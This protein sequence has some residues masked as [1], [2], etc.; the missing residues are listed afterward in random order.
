MG[1]GVCTHL[2][3]KISHKGGGGSLNCWQPLTKGG[4]GSRHD[5]VNKTWSVNLIRH[6][7]T[8][9][10]PVTTTNYPDIAK[11]YPKIPLYCWILPNICPHGLKFGPLWCHNNSQGDGHRGVIWVRSHNCTVTEPIKQHRSRP[12]LNMA[13]TIRKSLWFINWYAK[14]PF[15]LPK[16]LW[17]HIG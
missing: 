6:S 15:V 4:G 2:M 13:D 5:K 14:S 8:C 7:P 10:G 16:D 3:L 12:P 11:Y 17:R 1:R 9:N